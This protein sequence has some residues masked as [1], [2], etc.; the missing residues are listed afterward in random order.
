[1]QRCFCLCEAY[2]VSADDTTGDAGRQVR[3]RSGFRGRPDSWSFYFEEILKMGT[4]LRR[5]AF[6]SKQSESRGSSRCQD[7]GFVQAF[8]QVERAPSTRHVD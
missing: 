4:A 7:D 3:G 2:A 1:M 5:L 8:V 6:V